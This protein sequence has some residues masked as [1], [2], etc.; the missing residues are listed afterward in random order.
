MKNQK[1][2]SLLEVVASLVIITIVL[3]SFY[4]M[5]INAKKI[6]NSNMDR[7]V[8]I[9]LAEATLN[10]LKA[11]QY[12]YIEQPSNQTSY[13]FNSKKY[14][15]SNCSTENCKELYLMQLNGENYHLVIKVSQDEKEAKSNLLNIIVSIKNDEKNTQFNVEGY[16]N[17]AS[18]EE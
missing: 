1:G 2:F 16:I 10:R 11:D 8:M 6:S 18:K 4:P 17:N 14:T 13:L 5:I 9:N 15:Y 12:A 3:L 7:L